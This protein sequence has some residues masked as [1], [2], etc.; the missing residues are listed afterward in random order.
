MIPQIE[1]GLS[2][3]EHIIHELEVLLDALDNLSNGLLSHSVIRPGLLQ[4]FLRQVE[5]D[6]KVHYPEYELLL[7]KVEHYYNLLLINFK[8]DDFLAIQ[9]PLFV[10]HYTQQA[11]SFYNIRTVPVPYHINAKFSEDM[12]PSSYTWLHPKHQLL[13]MSYSTYVL[14]D[15]ANIH[16]CFH[17]GNTYFCEQVFL[18]Q[19]STKC[20]C[21]SAILGG[22]CIHAGIHIPIYIYL[23]I[24]I[25]KAYP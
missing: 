12:E 23:Y 24:Y 5:L 3:Y 15:T 16:N 2:Q 22:V 14:L 18:T 11:L 7:D 8:Y 10:K 19:H 17:F 4:S 25:Y 1:R 6:F 20:T 9:I 13:P 21:E